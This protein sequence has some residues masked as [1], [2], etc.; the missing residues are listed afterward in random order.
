MVV[1]LVAASDAHAGPEGHILRI[2]PRASQA[3]DSPVLT[4]VIEVNQVKPANQVLGVCSALSGNAE[5]DCVADA[6][7]RPQALWSPIEF[8][9]QN[10]FL[11][12]LVDGTD[13]PAK[14]LSKQRWAEAS[15]ESGV[16]TA[17]LI[18]LD[19]GA[20]MG[21]RIDEA[22]LV[23]TTFVNGMR[24]NDIANVMIFNDR[25]V[26]AASG[27]TKEKS[28]ALE[29][30]QNVPKFPVSG[31]TRPLGQI[32]QQAAT[33]GFRELNNVGVNVT[34]PM[35]Q[36]M[37]V[38]SSGAAGT[39]ATSV[40]PAAQFLSQ[41]MSKGRFPEDNLGLPKMPVPIISIWFPST[42]LEEL[43]ENARQFMEKLPNTEIG[44]GFFIVRDGQ[45]S[46]ADR[47]LQ[48]VRARFD[49]MWIV[50]WQ[51]ACV[52]P[53]I[54]QTFHLSFRNTD[55]LIAPDFT[56]QNVPVGIDPQAWPLDIDMEATLAEAEKNPVY[57]GGKVKVYGNFCWGGK[58]ERAELYMV[59]KNQEV[60]ATLQGG[61][62]E[63]AKNAQK[64][65]IEAGMRGQALATTDTYVEFEVPDKTKF[66]AGKKDAYTARLVL[67]DNVSKRTSA[68]TRDKIVTLKAQE[69]PLPI[70]L[71]GGIAF[72]GVVL[73]LLLVTAVRGGGSKR[74]ASNAA[75]PPRPVVSPAPAP[76]P[77]MAATP[78]PAFVSR[79]T[80][81]G[82]AG[83]FT[84]LP[85]M[86]MKAG[87]DGALCQILLN[88]P[89]VSG[90]HATMKIESGQLFVRDDN[91]NNG[92]TL[93]G[94]RLPAGVWSP[95]PNGAS[96]KFGPIEF[97]VS[98][99]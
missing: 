43:F 61:S 41:Y 97:N 65:L 32:V 31:R 88:E 21:S 16:G 73:L 80:L 22:K 38:L 6:V 91:S 28:K 47:I 3:E 8:P 44:G 2:D 57:P 46:R 75:A 45:S 54:T 48:A 95:V 69:A 26:V 34:V 12:V 49:K 13:Y 1:T 37:V 9:E 93:N 59:P 53:T 58:K 27:W 20:Q 55:P 99:E 5:L 68:V 23:A 85:G 19:A 94:Q 78:G 56:F 29:P 71:I 24:E 72:G 98:L 76:M 15:K 79:A 51:V 25:S 62:I 77:M 86:E 92:S 74:R 84:V 4:T 64:T 11:T 87:R 67:F 18:A 33:D 81:S 82:A 96:L 10:A 70:F 14:Y 39:D 66:L 60:P 63:D 36:S 90:T 17:W 35:H 40:G 30:L 89:R 50:K 83:I 42:Q 52:E 7:E